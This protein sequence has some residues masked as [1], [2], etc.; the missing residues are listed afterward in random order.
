VKLNAR[1]QLTV[2]GGALLVYAAL[3]FVTYLLTPLDQLTAPGQAV[4]ATTIA[5]PRWVF[6]SANA[7][8][9]LVVYGLLGTGAYWFA[10]RLQLPCLYREGAGWRAWVVWPM[11]LGLG[12]GGLMV[13]GDHLFSVAAKTP[14]FPHPAFPLS[15]LTS[16]SAGIGEEILARGFIFGLWGLGLTAILRGQR[17]RS[18]GLWIANIIAALAFGALHIPTAMLLLGAKS[19]ADLPMG[20]LAEL[21]VL[22]GILGL[23]AGERMMREGLV[24]AMGLHFWA[25]VVWHVIW[26]MIG[27]GSGL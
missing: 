16:A 7:G 6:A 15:V 9:V 18:A 3:V 8:I 26:P 5:M 17:G 2:L 22:N 11:L 12:M 25:D 21:F 14:A 1:K 24:A 23:A 4:P 19:P 20:T 27:F 10:L 13:I